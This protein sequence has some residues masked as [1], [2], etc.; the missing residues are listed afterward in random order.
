MQFTFFLHFF[1]FFLPK[2]CRIYCMRGRDIWI[3]YYWVFLLIF[4][5][6]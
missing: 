1:I 4:F 6:L 3:T 2:R 5:Y